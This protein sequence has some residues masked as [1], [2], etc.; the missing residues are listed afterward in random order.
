MSVPTNTN[1]PQLPAHLM[2]FGTA[3][4]LGL[5]AVGGISTGKSHPRIS[6]KQNR[7]RLVDDQGQEFVVPQ[8]FL[9]IIIVG[10][11]PVVSKIYYAGAYNPNAADFEAPTCFSDNGT[12]PSSRATTPQSPTCGTCPLNA[13]GS[14]IT[15]AGAKIKACSDS[16]KMAVILADNPTGL[17]YELRVPGA[18]LEN[19]KS[20]VDMLNERKVP[21]PGLVI[22]VQFDENTDYPKLV[23]S[24]QTY[25]TEAQKAAVLDVLD[26]EEVKEAVGLSD[27]A[28]NPGPAIAPPVPTFTSPAPQF[29]APT[30]MAPPLPQFQ[31][32][33]NPVQAEA[34][35]APVRRK[36]RTQA[37]MQAEVSTQ[38]MQ[39]MQPIPQPPAPQF[40][41]TQQAAPQGAGFE[42]PAFLKRDT[43]HA[44]AAAASVP[45][46]PQ[47]TDAALDAMLKDAMS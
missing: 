13:W 44:A 38:P 22:R 42:I 39:N 43:P 14:K 1:V 47:T 27:I 21:L 37:E 8:L 9:D 10:A 35:P 26:G 20:I 12:A 25:I 29:I 18:S 40:Q 34:A 31:A 16:K 17:V 32:A 4:N 30:P 33:A 45:M 24:P 7:F 2:N 36:R 11:N 3:A 15:P 46:Q 41:H 19:I 5:S 23:F 28:F 6:I